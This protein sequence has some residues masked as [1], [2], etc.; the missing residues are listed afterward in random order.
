[1]HTLFTDLNLRYAPLASNMP[2]PPSKR[3][4]LLVHVLKSQSESASALK[5]FNA[6]SQAIACTLAESIL[7]ADHSEILRLEA[8]KHD[9]IANT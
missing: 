6:P 8:T 7:S 4:R 2:I 5:P 9:D 1:M 3:I